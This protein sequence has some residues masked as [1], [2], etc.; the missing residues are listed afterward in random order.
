[1]KTLLYLP[2]IHAPANPI[3][4]M[5][6]AQQIWQQNHSKITK[7]SAPPPKIIERIRH[8][9]A[10]WTKPSSLGGSNE[11]SVKHSPATPMNQSPNDAR[12]FP[13]AVKSKKAQSYVTRNCNASCF[14]AYCI[15]GNRSR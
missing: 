4:S 9:R 5:T 1:M 8:D 11:L 12:L 15:V 2:R 3:P 7:T 10:P 13:F 6:P 14:Y